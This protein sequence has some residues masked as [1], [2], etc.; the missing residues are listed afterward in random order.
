MPPQQ[1]SGRAFA[2]VGFVDLPVERPFDKFHGI[3]CR[4]KLD[5]KPL[6]RVVHRRRQVSP[7]VD[8]L[9]HGFFDGAQHLLRCN[10]TVGSRHGAVPARRKQPNADVAYLFRPLRCRGS[11]G[12]RLPPCQRREQKRRQIGRKL[13]MRRFIRSTYQR[14]RQ[15]PPARQL[16]PP[17]R[18]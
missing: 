2:V 8:N 7:P 13:H 4:S 10:V 11:R 1:T 18:P 14:A 6:D 3:D 12:W 17:S 16:Q 9:T 5:A 15:G